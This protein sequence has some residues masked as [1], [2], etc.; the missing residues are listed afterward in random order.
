MKRQQS[1]AARY[2]AFVAERAWSIIIVCALITAVCITLAAQLRISTDL[3]ALLPRGYP[4]VEDLHKVMKRIGGSASLT[5][6]IESPD[7]KTNERFAEDLVARLRS[8]MKD[9]IVNIDYK[10]DALKTFYERHAA[11]YLPLRDLKAMEHDL[12]DATE[13][14]KLS[15]SPVPYDL[16]L[17]D[18]EKPAAA[19]GDAATAKLEELNQRVKDAEKQFERFPDGYYAGENGKLLAV[20]I[21]PRS[22]GS[23]ADTAHEF[24]AHV[25][26][27]VAELN[28]AKYDPQM[29]VGYT[30][31]Y[32]VTLD[33]HAAIQRDLLSTATL[34]VSLIA[35]VV[36]L[37]FRRIRVVW[38]LGVTL[39]CGCAWAFGL[40]WLTVGYLN[41]QTA[42]LGSIIAGTGINYGIILLARYLQ[43][44]RSGQTEIQALE[45]A[46]GTT[47]VATGTAAA[48]TA[49]SFGTLVIARISSFRH[50][51]IIGGGGILFCWILTFTMLPAMLI[52]TERVRKAVGRR[53]GAP[54]W[55]EP[56]ASFPVLH[57]R[58]TAGLSLA[59]AAL[60]AVAF[61]RFLP[62]V[63]ETDGRNL[64]NKSSFTSGTA[65][66]DDRVGAILGQSMTP[67]FVVTESL[68]E[69]RRVCDVLNERVRR[70]GEARAPIQKC[71]SIYSLLPEEQEQKLNIA[72]RLVQKLDKIPKQALP[73]ETRERLQRLR[74]RIVLEKVQLSSLPEELL[75]PFRELSGDVGRLVA[76]YPPEGRDLWIQENLYNF[77]DAIRRIDIGDGQVVTS[78]G[79]AVIFADILRMIARDAP[80]TTLLSLMGVIGFVFIA[81]KSRGTL[82][83]VFS[84]VIGVIWMIGLQA[85]LHVKVNFLNFVA[86]PTT[87]GIAADYSLNLF[88]R[89]R[90]ELEHPDV[91]SRVDAVHRALRSTGSAVFLCS[92]TTIIGYFTLIIADNMALVSFGKLAMIGEACTVVSSLVLLPA[93]LVLDKRA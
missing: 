41:I 5:V 65:K 91:S 80:R 76:V 19:K 50:F 35:L 37:Y 88:V 72:G 1:F 40:A 31:A 58:I 32:Q 89:Y 26:R 12:D 69:A 53:R 2:A 4:S 57:P 75:R 77:T 73:K 16:G 82:H 15:A 56:L 23:D 39:V 64:R 79:D 20:F 7:L 11:V 22:S 28:P 61:I 42:F 52:L 71:R 59:L 9:Q 60:C 78:S 24:I 45:C 63:L 14:A 86:L 18:D 68:E 13:K 51:A 38:M 90:V 34:C 48:T 8:D 46:I 74:D 81:L 33:E 27:I 17:D 21:R 10:V 36:V 66:L 44:R 67:G 92:L 25:K 54:M 93:T 43:E 3:S 70:E 87:F 30:G 85:L 83:V 6:A 29:K 62:H 84:L 47:F 55:P 49:I